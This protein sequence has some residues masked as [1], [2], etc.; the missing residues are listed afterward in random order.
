MRAK[1]L[2]VLTLL[3]V[4]A[5]VLTAS[6]GKKTIKPD[7]P[8][9]G[10]GETGDVAPD[11]S[12]EER[13]RQRDLDEE[14]LRRQREEQLRQEQ[15]RAEAARREM[16]PA[17]GRVMEEDI[18]FPFDSAALS[19]E[20]QAKLREKADWLRRYPEV[21]VIIEGHCDERGTSEY[22]LALGDRRAESAKRFLVNLGISPARLTTISYGE[23]R[24]LDPG[25]NEFAWAKNRR[26]HFVI[27]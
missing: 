19:P 26:A 9:A 27:E 21:S 14:R 17:R 22:N 10:Y 11:L 5:M 25:H 16:A 24:P 18:H 23:E 15:I 3:I 13:A 7:T 6:C 12:A 20:A 1:Q 8:A 2:M 4:V